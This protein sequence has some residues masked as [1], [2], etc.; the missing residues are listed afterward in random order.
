ACAGQTS[1]T[2]TSG[3]GSYERLRHHR[4]GAGRAG[5][6]VHHRRRAV[7][8][9]AVRW[10][11]LLAVCVALTCLAAAVEPA[12][13]AAL[14]PPREAAGETAPASASPALL[15]TRRARWRRVARPS[16]ATLR[17]IAHCETGGTMDP[18]AVSRG[19]T[20]RGLLQFD[21]GTWRSVGGRGDP[22]A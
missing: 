15:E 16:L 14:T 10:L 22:A 12:D 17:R 18:R 2:S 20:Y 3:S 5:G 4:R 13:P 7:E 11:A 19:G 21:L 9:P 1:R 6:R 8:A